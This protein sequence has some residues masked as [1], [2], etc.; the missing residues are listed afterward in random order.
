MKEIDGKRITVENSFGDRMYV[1]K[2][3]LEQME[4]ADHFDSEFPMTKTGLAELLQTVQDHIFTVYFHKKPTVENT[5]ES[6]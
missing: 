1:S 5:L 6:L 4:S 3:I 2:D